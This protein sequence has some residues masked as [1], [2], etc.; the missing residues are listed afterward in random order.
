MAKWQ[1]MAGL[2]P[3]IVKAN[4]GEHFEGTV[5]VRVAIPN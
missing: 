1:K 5:Q 4:P 3:A 2:N